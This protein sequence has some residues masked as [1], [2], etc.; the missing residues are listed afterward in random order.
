MESGCVGA[1]AVVLPVLL[2]DQDAGPTSVDVPF[3]YVAIAGR[4]LS[5]D[6]IVT[7]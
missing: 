5:A 3:T 7:P 6:G 4:E 2:I 1:G